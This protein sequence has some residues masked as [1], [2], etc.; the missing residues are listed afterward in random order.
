M[1]TSLVLKTRISNCFLNLC[2]LHTRM[3]VL[4]TFFP[5]SDSGCARMSLPFCLSEGGAALNTF[6]LPWP[7]P[8]TAVPLLRQLYRLSLSTIWTVLNSSARFDFQGSIYSLI[9]SWEYPDK[10]GI[11]CNIV[12]SNDSANFLL[13][14]QLLRGQ[15]SAQKIILSAAVAI[16]PF[17]GSDG[18]PMSNVSAFAEVLDHIGS[19]F[20]TFSILT[21]LFLTTSVQ[22]L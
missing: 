11:G 13:F 5:F 20:T 2:R 1:P 8:K 4:F 15:Y 14:L 19:P 22:R 9:H 17:L 18:T 10:Q 7:P 21:H 6:L 16:Q 12:S 3:Y